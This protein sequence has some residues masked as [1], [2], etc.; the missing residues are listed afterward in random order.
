MSHWVV[1]LRFIG[2]SFGRLEHGGW[3]LRCLTKQCELEW[4]S[5]F[6]NQ[7]SRS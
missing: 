3:E 1:G 2:S 7:S 4:W 5:W 6:V